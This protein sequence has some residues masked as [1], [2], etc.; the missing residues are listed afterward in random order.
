MLYHERSGAIM[1]SGL[2][3]NAR[4]VLLAISHHLGS[5]ETCWPGLARL[6]L[7]TGLS[8]STVRRT[9]QTLQ[10]DGLLSVDTR[11]GQSHVYTVQ[12]SKLP[13]SQRHPFQSE[14][15]VTVTPP[16]L[17]QRHPTPVTVTPEGFKKDSLEGD[18]PHSPPE[19][20]SAQPPVDKS[21]APSETVDKSKP[22]RKRSSALTLEQIAAVEIPAALSALEE[23]PRAWSE[24]CEHRRT[25]KGKALWKDPEQVSRLLRKLSRDHGKNLDIITA[26]DEATAAGWQGVFPKP[27]RRGAT[28]PAAPDSKTTLDPEMVWQLMLNAMG[29]VGG[30][31]LPTPADV[32][33]L[34]PAALDRAITAL[35]GPARWTALCRSRPD[36]LHFRVRPS[37]VR[38]FQGGRHV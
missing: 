6:V 27:F 33:A 21:T 29:S 12:W 17:S 30:R 28:P 20:T 36:D 5:N 2:K 18:T 22:K 26:L 4:L 32:P 34:A 9:V 31:R 16:P 14:T 25:L 1:A 11:P 38:N 15:P 8:E 35:G 19:G 24:F 23:F 13:L 10:R 3:P 37:F 7:F